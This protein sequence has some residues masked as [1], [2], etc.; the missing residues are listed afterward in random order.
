MSTLPLRFWLDNAHFT[1]F[2][3]A[4]LG[5]FAA[6][7]LNYDSHRQGADLKVLLRA[8]GF[9][10][11]TL[12]ALA[13]STGFDY[14]WVKYASFG[15]ELIGVGLFAFGFYIEPAPKRPGAEQ[16]KEPASKIS[17]L[18]LIGLSSVLKSVLLKLPILIWGAVLIRIWQFATVGLIKDLTGLRTAILFIFLSRLVS[19]AELFS[20][21]SNLLVFNL[22][23]EYSYLWMLENV[24]LLIG[25]IILIKWAFYYLR[26]RPGP[27]LYITFVATSIIVFIISTVAFSGFL[28]TASQKNSLNSLQKSGAVFEFSIKELQ[29]QTNLAA[30]SLAQRDLLIQGVQENNISKTKSG[31]GDPIK[32]L[33][34]GGAAVTN[35]A[36]EILAVSG[37]FLDVGESLVSD[38]AIIKTL[39]GKP[40]ASIILEQLQ[41]SQQMVVR[42]AYPIVTDSKVR[43]AVVVDFPIDQAFVD[44]IKE[45]TRLDVS[46]NVGTTHT[47]ATFLDKNNRRITGTKITNQEVI[48][49]IN[50]KQKESWTWAGIET[51]V[52][53]SY[54]TV[55]RSLSDADNMNV[56]SLLVGQ[57]RQVV[58]GQVDRSIKLTFLVTAML[59][60]ISLTPLYYLSRSIS[61]A[62]KT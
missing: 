53:Q 16:E 56:G 30:Y 62:T 20:G 29:S 43:G 19:I 50:G 55:Y 59:I 46:I 13:A 47:A 12:W 9:F 33:N 6:G 35:R 34:V 23:R 15:L 27:Q 52:D 28:F 21:S 44:N 37:T 45:L 18:S 5:F 57:D 49:L 4:A 26:F 41:D 2:I 38:P 60:L 8:I 24:L 48:G 11:L 36:G 25:A 3:I 54:L 42:S 39:E 61:Q 22:T 17:A 58:I 10:V 1:I 14:F 31:L 7:W 32:E 40:T 51:I